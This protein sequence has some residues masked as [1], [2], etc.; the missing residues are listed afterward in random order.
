VICTMQQGVAKRIF[1]SDTSE[2]AK[3]LQRNETVR[4]RESGGGRWTEAE[5][6][7]KGFDIGTKHFESG[8]EAITERG[9]ESKFFQLREEGLHQS[10]NRSV[11]FIPHVLED[12]EKILLQ[13]MSLHIDDFE[14]PLGDLCSLVHLHLQGESTLAG[15]V[16]SYLL[17]GMQLGKHQSKWDS[18]IFHSK[19]NRMNGLDV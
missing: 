3:L 2:R 7:L 9:R 16:G 15:M 14:E 13:H 6:N 5:S 19:G 4:A 10:I 1:L 8:G 17:S 12:R 18:N 11:I